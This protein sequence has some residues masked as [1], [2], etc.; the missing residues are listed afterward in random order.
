MTEDGVRG[1]R[2]DGAGGRT[3]KEAGQ[4][5]RQDQDRNT[6]EFGGRTG[7]AGRGL[8]GRPAGNLSATQRSVA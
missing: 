6:D 1:T 4:D 8:A 3:G 5:R 2:Q 7:W